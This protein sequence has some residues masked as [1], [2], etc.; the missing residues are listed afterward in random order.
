MVD[1]RGPDGAPQLPDEIWA[2]ILF[3]LEGGVG[4]GLALRYCEPNSLLE[5]QA[6][7][8]RL[9]LVCRKFEQIFRQQH[10]LCRGL[11]V[12]V[13][14]SDQRLQSL[15]SW[16]QEHSNCVQNLAAY[17]GSPGLDSAIDLLAGPP[18]KLASVFL[19]DCSI[20]A[21]NKLTVFTS[22]TS[23]ELVEPQVSVLNLTPLQPLA[24]LQKLVVADGLFITTQLPPHL[25]NLTLNHAVVTAAE[26]CSCVTSLKKLRLLDSQLIG[27]HSDGI[28]ACSAVQLLVCEQGQLQAGMGHL[29]LACSHELPFTVPPGLSSLEKLK[30]LSLAIASTGASLP[31]DVAQYGHDLSCLQGLTSLEE[32]SVHSC[33]DDIFV[34]SGV[35]ALQKLSVLSLNVA[36]NEGADDEP[37]VILDIDWAALQMLK[38]L[39]IDAP[40][41]VC[42]CSIVG[43][44]TVKQ[45]THITWGH[46]AYDAQSTKCFAALMYKLAKYR[47]EVA[48]VLD[49][50]AID[51]VF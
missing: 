49:K 5:A 22:L 30:Y 9:R 14:L 28:A 3:H 7:Y 11:A 12:P 45:L 23:C 21:L 29:C 20:S 38:S 16:L 4:D 18:P 43:L 51:N 46:S 42:Q 19:C 24:N 41:F 26:Q 36:P 40:T 34:P 32:L 17:C 44:A 48:V 13:S 33:A 25:T 27:L 39:R 47:P 31:Y 15:E 6:E 35:T 10:Q 1:K 8:Y 2:K 37:S 50:D